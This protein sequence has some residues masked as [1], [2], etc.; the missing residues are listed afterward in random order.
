M[1][2]DSDPIVFPPMDPEVFERKLAKWKARGPK[3]RKPPRNAYGRP[4]RE[5][6]DHDVFVKHV[7]SVLAGRR[8]WRE[9]T[10]RLTGREYNR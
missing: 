3:P 5:R 4:S 1:T 10:G 2:D 9:E 6:L 7:D 8:K